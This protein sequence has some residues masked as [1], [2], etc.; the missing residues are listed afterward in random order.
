MHMCY[1]YSILSKNNALDKLNWQRR[2]Y[3]RLLQWGWEI[4]LNSPETKSK[5]I[6]NTM[7]SYQ[8]SPR[9]IRGRLVNAAGTSTFANWPLL[10]WGSSPPADTG[11][12]GLQLFWLLHFEGLAPR[13]WGM[14]CWDYNTSK[15]LGEDLHLKEEFTIVKFLT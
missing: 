3:S 15:R 2:L 11:R 13:S 6:L 14:T 8:K 1:M 10:K 9:G 7:I 5:N 4:K 12:K